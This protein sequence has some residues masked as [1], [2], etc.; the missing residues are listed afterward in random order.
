VAV[1]SLVIGLVTSVSG[2]SLQD[3]V[4]DIATLTA[5]AER[6]DPE[7]QTRL[8]AYLLEGAA[9]DPDKARDWLSRAAAQGDAEAERRL[10]QVYAS[11]ASEGAGSGEMEHWYSLAAGRGDASAQY[12]LGEMLH[13]RGSPTPNSMWDWLMKRLMELERTAG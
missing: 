10:A 5:S 1:L 11:G 2:A 9:A 7:A 12:D 3:A 13:A 8:G 6:G 4:P